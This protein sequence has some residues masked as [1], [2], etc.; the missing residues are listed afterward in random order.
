[1]TGIV[2]FINAFSSELT[3]GERLT[4]AISLNITLEYQAERPQGIVS[5]GV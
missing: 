1:M 2:E 4:K 5:F 3:V